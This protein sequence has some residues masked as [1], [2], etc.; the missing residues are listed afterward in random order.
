MV[1]GN[2]PVGFLVEKYIVIIITGS[3]YQAKEGILGA[4]AAMLQGLGLRKI[5]LFVIL[6]IYLYCHVMNVHETTSG[7]FL[8]HGN[9]SRGAYG[10]GWK[11]W[12]GI[13]DPVDS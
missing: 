10:N 13:I 2:S 7:F 11:D 12:Q 8:P 1:Q 6:G 9:S 5:Y 4:G 3:A